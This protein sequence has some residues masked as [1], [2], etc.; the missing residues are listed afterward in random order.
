MSKLFS[1]LHVPKILEANGFIIVSQRGNHTKLRKVGIPK[2][3]VIVPADR[4]EI[5]HGTKRSILRQSRLD[6]I[7]FE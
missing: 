3:T 2:L 5:P 4:K 1:S 6:I 7:D